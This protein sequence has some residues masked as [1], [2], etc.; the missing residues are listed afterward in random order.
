MRRPYIFRLE[1]N[2]AVVRRFIEVLNKKDLSFLV[3]N[4]TSPDYFDHLFRRDLKETTKNLEMMCKGFPD[5]QFTIDDII[6]EGDK[7]WALITFTGIHTGEWMGLAPT[8]KKVSYTGVTI[9]RISNGKY[10]EGWTIYD[11][12]DFYKQLGLV[13][14]T[15]KAKKLFPQNIS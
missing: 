15:E 11:F 7:V 9:R 2:K 5:F 10:A 6:A 14:Y 1:E 4:L 12:L 8:G 13:E 3:N